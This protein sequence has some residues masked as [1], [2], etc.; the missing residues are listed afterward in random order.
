[1]ASEWMIQVVE[2]FDDEADAREALAALG[3]QDGYRGGRVLAPSSAKPG[4]RVQ[5]FFE[6]EILNFGA[7]LGW[8][9]DGVRWVTVHDCLRGWL[10]LGPR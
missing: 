6:E 9:P 2:S 5:A 7:T 10:G 8:L 4:W 3:D 1:M